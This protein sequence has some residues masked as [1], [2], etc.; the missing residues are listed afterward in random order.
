MSVSPARCFGCGTCRIDPGRDW[1][2]R[3]AESRYVF[4]LCGW[5]REDLGGIDWDGTI[6][7]ALWGKAA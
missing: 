1:V 5:C 6:P 2:R 3:E 4:F 7:H